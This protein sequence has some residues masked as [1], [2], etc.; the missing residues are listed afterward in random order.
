MGNAVRN[1]HQGYRRGGS[2]P[3]PCHSWHPTLLIPGSRSLSLCKYWWGHW[4]SGFPA[5]WHHW[6]Y[7]FSVKG[8]EEIILGSGCD[9]GNL[10]N[11]L[12]IIN[13]ISLLV[14]LP[15]I[16]HT[17]LFVSCWVV[18]ETS[19]LDSGSWSHETKNYHYLQ[20]RL[21][22]TTFYHQGFHSDNATV[23]CHSLTY[24]VWANPDTVW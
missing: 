17:L 1:G 20:I 2:H 8:A 21:L 9:T 23:H 14:L 12:A 24:R 7:G 5:T 18:P 13:N 19:N 3:P 4:Y 6:Y 15:V 10:T 16:S 11:K 22:T